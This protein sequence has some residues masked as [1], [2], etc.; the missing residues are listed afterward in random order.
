M[1]WY[2]LIG[3]LFFLSVPL[4]VSCE[5]QTELSESTIPEEA[6]EEAIKEGTGTTAIYTQ[7][8]EKEAYQKLVEDKV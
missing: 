2:G 8:E 3:V 5:R 1:K 4:S 6:G 7:K